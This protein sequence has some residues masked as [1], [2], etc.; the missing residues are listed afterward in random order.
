[1]RRSSAF[2]LAAAVI[3]SAS[4]AVPAPPA[5]AGLGGLL[6]I[7][8]APL[9]IF[10]GHRHFRR[11]SARREAAGH[12]TARHG[13]SRQPGAPNSSPEPK[14]S[15]DRSA[16]RGATPRRLEV[17]DTYEDMLGYALWPAQYANRF[18]T[19]GYGDIGNAL[20][21]PAA[22]ASTV[23]NAGSA[24]SAGGENSAWPV[25]CEPKASDV[26]GRMAGQIEQR[27]QLTAPQHASLEKLREALAEAIDKARPVCGSGA[28]T[29]PSAR[30]QAVVDELWALRDAEALVR[31]PMADFYNSLNDDQKKSLIG[32]MP[33]RGRKRDRAAD[34]VGTADNAGRICLQQANSATDAPMRKIEQTVAPTPEQRASLQA[35]QEKS[36][37][38]AQYLMASCPQ[39][40]ATTPVDRLDS[41]GERVNAMLYAAMSI[42]PEL[43]AFYASLSDEQKA[44]LN[45]LG[46]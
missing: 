25:L 22:A 41:A 40:P 11:H 14:S 36:A 27:V 42:A 10:G 2:L 3:A 43:E 33:A 17:A 45:A 26:A 34:A 6:G 12:R 31:A 44:K 30:L 37:G 21:V 16:N 38:L 8:T 5:Q 15:V 20:I 24:R 7:M 4:V 13:V 35:L 28:P 18:W 46:G 23:G 19:H 32:P 1:M 39:Q 9:H 29:T